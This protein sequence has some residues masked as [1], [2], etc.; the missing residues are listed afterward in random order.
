MGQS[1]GQ[2]PAIFK[3]SVFVAEGYNN[4]WSLNSRNPNE[5]DL[6]GIHTQKTKSCG[7]ENVEA[8]HDIT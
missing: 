3:W 7:I 6:H 8:A 1:G 5:T 4:N 2:V